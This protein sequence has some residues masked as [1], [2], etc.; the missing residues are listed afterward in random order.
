MR[1]VTDRLKS[2]KS[3][4]DGQ[5]TPLRRCGALHQGSTISLHPRERLGEDMNPCR[6]PWPCVEIDGGALWAQSGDSLILGWL[7]F[8]VGPRSQLHRRRVGRIELVR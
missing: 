8:G 3:S 5:A 4:T 1:E 2:T 7:G 6:G